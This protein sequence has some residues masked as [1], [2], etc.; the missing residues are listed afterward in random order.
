MTLFMYYDNLNEHGQESLFD[1]QLCHSISD[2]WTVISFQTL[3]MFIVINKY[4]TR[5]LRCDTLFC[6][7]FKYIILDNNGVL[8]D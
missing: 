6:V 8:Q 7:F 4:V 2:D 5:M 1:K 3:A